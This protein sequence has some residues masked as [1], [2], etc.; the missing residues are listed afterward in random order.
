MLQPFV[1]WFETLACSR[2]LHDDV[3]KWKHF[4]RYWPFVREI[5]RSPVNSPHKG[6]WRGTLIF[7]LICTWINGWV[8]NCEA[9]DLRCD[10]AHCDV[11]VMFLICEYLFHCYWYEKSNPYWTM[12]RN[13]CYEENNIIYMNGFLEKSTVIQ[14]MLGHSFYPYH[15]C[16]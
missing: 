6:Q 13:V 14:I 3:M 4:P 2:T 16:K 12:W 7:S 1:T 5:H 8:N 15:L 10:R 11:I 9:R